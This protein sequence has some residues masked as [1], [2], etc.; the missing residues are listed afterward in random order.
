MCFLLNGISFFAVIGCLLAMQ[1]PPM[2]G[3]RGASPFDH[4]ID[5]FRYAWKEIAVRRVLGLMAAST[6]AGMPILV[7]APIFADDIFRRGSRALGFLMGAM[8]IGAVL[9]TLMIARRTRLSRLPGVM[10]ISGLCLGVAY[11]L[12]AFSPWFYV[13]LGMMPL[14]GYAMMSQMASANTTVQT[15]IHESYR[16]RVMALYSMTVV[17]LGPFGSLASGALAQRFGARA[18]VAMGGVIAIAA[19]A[20]YGWKV[21]TETIA[22]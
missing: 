12:F 22:A 15:S 2:P 20:V 6:L 14:I 1:L 7:L 17:G 16:G 5:G 9:G 8:G 4:L 18:A 11:V 13:S 21:R 3:E 19:A 10:A